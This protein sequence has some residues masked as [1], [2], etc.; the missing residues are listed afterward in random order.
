[1]TM[2]R[3]RKIC[4]VVLGLA[5]VA[6]GTDRLFLGGPGRP[7]AASASVLPTTEG[8]AP[9]TPQDAWA[10]PTA[11]RPPTLASRL[12]AAVEP[13]AVD[14]T[15]M[16]DAFTIAET[17]LPELQEP[18]PAPTTESPEPAEPQPTA[19]EVFATRHTLTSVILT[20]RG[21]SA[22]VDGKIVPLGQAVDGFT[23]LRLTPESAIFG[24]DGDEVELRLRRQGL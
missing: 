4:L 8:A 12:E 10:A 13:F 18:A 24:A 1:M 21:G 20:S 5:V 3:S 19:G 2:T 6:L 23:L 22:V 15:K 16:R 7:R 11:E 14:P 9:A 17:W